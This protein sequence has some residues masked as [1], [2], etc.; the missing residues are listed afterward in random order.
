MTEIKEPSIWV[1][2]APPDAARPDDFWFDISAMPAINLA[3]N[4]VGSIAAGR[5]AEPGRERG[6]AIVT[7]DDLRLW[8]WS[9]T[10]WV[11]I[12]SVS[13]P[14]GPT[15]PEGAMGPVGPTGASPA[16]A[17]GKG[18][19]VTLDDDDRRRIDVVPGEGVRIIENSVA[20]D[21]DWLST[22]IGER[23][24]NVEAGLGLVAAEDDGTVLLSV[25]PGPGIR[26]DGGLVQVDP[27]FVARFTE[28]RAGLT[29]SRAGDS[30]RYLEVRPGAGV[31]VDGSGVHVDEM[32]VARVVHNVLEGNYYLT[33]VRAASTE[34]LD[35]AFTDRRV[36]G[37]WIN[38]GDRILVKDQTD[39]SENGLYL[40]DDEGLVRTSDTDDLRPGVRVRVGEG[41]L[42]ADTMWSV[43]VGLA[44]WSQANKEAGPASVHRERIPGGSGTGP[45][46]IQHRLG[47][48][49]VSI[50]VYEEDTGNEFA[51]TASCADDN[52]A[53]VTMSAFTESALWVV[54]YG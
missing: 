14:P 12:G 48:R 18:T 41:A 22:Q 50:A 53:W 32:W 16:L 15:G 51:A 38:S 27:S 45:F 13:G 43:D 20:V 35:L 49:W 36:D 34:P 3:V 7:E 52:F 6:D 44:T 30:I 26:L 28:P 1:G 40:Y 47:R 10:E 42:Q 54:V 33:P 5:P 2:E 19:A 8:V 37:V 29:A 39:P 11:N 46:P 17:D 4:V 25:N 23:A 21:P 24:P 9:G 31:V